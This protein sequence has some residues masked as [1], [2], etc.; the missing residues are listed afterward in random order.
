[1]EYFQ[2]IHIDNCIY[3]KIAQNQY[4]YWKISAGLSNVLASS[5]L[6]HNS[7]NM[8]LVLPAALFC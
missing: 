5:Y 3:N 1:M 8:V 7:N 4:V 6:H 2:C